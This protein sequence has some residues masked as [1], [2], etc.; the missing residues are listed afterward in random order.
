MERYP[1]P[2]TLPS[3]VSTKVYDMVGELYVRHAVHTNVE[4][5]WAH[6]IVDEDTFQVLC[7]MHMLE[8]T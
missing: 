7:I 4:W 5:E 3:N 8:G 6:P 1:Y 2:P